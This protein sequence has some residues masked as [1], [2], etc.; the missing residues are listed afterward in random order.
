MKGMNH[1]GYTKLVPD[2]GFKITFVELF[3]TTSKWLRAE[4]LH[5]KTAVHKLLNIDHV[6]ILN[7][8]T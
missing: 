3:V 1:V 2:Q 8:Y 5:D 7:E 4:E 6:Y